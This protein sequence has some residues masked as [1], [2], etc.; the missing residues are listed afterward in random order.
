M[1]K[2]KYRNNPKFPAKVNLFTAKQHA[3]EMGLISPY[4]AGWPGARVKLVLFGSL[5]LDDYDLKDQHAIR[6]AIHKLYE[7]VEIDDYDLAGGGWAPKD[8]DYSIQVPVALVD[9]RVAGDQS[10]LGP[11]VWR[12][13]TDVYA[14]IIKIIDRYEP[15]DATTLRGQNLEHEDFIPEELEE[16]KLN[17]LSREITNAL[18]GE[19]ASYAAIDQLARDYGYPRVQR[20]AA[21]RGPMRMVIIARTIQPLSKNNYEKMVRKMWDDFGVRIGYTVPD[22]DVVLLAVQS[23][24]ETRQYANDERYTLLPSSWYVEF[25]GIASLR[26]DHDE[27]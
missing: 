9:K 22:D 25:D 27:A 15:I 17:R 8:T 1:R 12:M 23:T 20:H 14:A 5:F 19:P 13:I 16:T 2:R 11:P 4:T 10:E 18:A 6:R 3:R 7:L 24:P 26:D 21:I